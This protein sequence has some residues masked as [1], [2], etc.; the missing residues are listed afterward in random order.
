M[1]TIG[2]L[3]R[4]VAVLAAFFVALYQFHFCKLLRRQQALMTICL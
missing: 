2:K 1:S 4:A 3:G